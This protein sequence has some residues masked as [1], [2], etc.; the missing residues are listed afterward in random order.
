M[1]RRFYVYLGVGYAAPCLSA[2]LFEPRL[3]RSFAQGG[4]SKH[5]K[6]LQPAIASPEPALEARGRAGGLKA[7]KRPRSNNLERQRRRDVRS[8]EAIRASTIAFVRLD[9]RNVSIGAFERMA[10]RERQHETR[11]QAAKEHSVF[12][13][14]RFH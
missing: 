8:D 14:F 9:R 5:L 6:D 10:A 3:R 12:W 7:D 13:A 1:A 11:Q 2:E 4:E